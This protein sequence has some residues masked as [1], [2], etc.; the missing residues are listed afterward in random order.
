M[1]AALSHRSRVACSD[2]LLPLGF[3]QNCG[4]RPTSVGGIEEKGIFDIPQK[5]HSDRNLRLP[6]AAQKRLG[7]E[8]VVRC[9][10]NH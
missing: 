5:D 8:V 3:F 4:T 10:S 1:L 2:S 7:L 6:F 9:L